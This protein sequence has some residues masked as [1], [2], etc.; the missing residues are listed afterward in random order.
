MN[1]KSKSVIIFIFGVSS[2]FLFL[3][4]ESNKRMSNYLDSRTKRINIVYSIVNDRYSDISN[5]VEQLYKTQK[6]LIKYLTT[7]LPH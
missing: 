2:I 6:L 5:K 1:I 3:K 4:N 7:H